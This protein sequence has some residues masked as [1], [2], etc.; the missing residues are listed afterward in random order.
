MTERFTDRDEA[1]R[2][3][4]ERLE[5]LD[6]ADPVVLALPRGGVPVALP[7]ARA[8]DAPLDLLFVRKIGVPGH[9]ELA[10]GAVVEGDPPQTVFNVDILASLR[11]GEA[12]FA[13]AVE[14]RLAEI[15]DRRQHYLGGRA[16]VSVAGRTAVVVDDGIATGAT[17]K[18]A[19][20][21]LR[22]Q[23]PAAIVLAVPVAPPDTL[24]ELDPLVDRIVCLATP[25]PFLAVGAHYD[26]FAQVGDDAVARMLAEAGA[27]SEG[28]P[29]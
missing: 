12:D 3:L 20:K 6:L 9:E 18:A 13:G 29:S 23:G 14:N 19:L 2:Y 27:S 25:T 7:V 10:A 24:T 4:A 16:R 26:R 21:A 17:V 22:S 11:K 5:A 28:T 15:A 8:L 1:G